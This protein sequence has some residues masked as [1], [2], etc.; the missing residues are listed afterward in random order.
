MARPALIAVDH[1]LCHSSRR[2]LEI[3]WTGL[4]PKNARHQKANQSGLLQRLLEHQDIVNL[5]NEYAYVLDTVMVDHTAATSW[6]NL[7]T[8]DATVIFPFGVFKGRDSMAQMC[9]D[10]ETRFQRMIVR[11]PKYFLLSDH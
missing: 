8:E 4:K 7:M 1:P 11:V 6:A 3:D 5:L 10:A 9:L 2:P